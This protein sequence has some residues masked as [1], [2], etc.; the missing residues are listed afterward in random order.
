M[1]ILSPSEYKPTDKTHVSS[2]Q[3]VIFFYDLIQIYPKNKIISWIEG[4]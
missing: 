2:K 1:L 4:F 3:T